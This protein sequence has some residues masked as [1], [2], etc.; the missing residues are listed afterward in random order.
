MKSVEGE[1]SQKEF[2]RGVQAAENRGGGKTWENIST[3]ER[4]RRT[5]LPGDKAA[6]PAK[7]QEAIKRVPNWNRK[8]KKKKKG[9]DPITPR[10]REHQSKRSKKK[11]KKRV[12]KA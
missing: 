4:R 7:S 8:G 5:P 3:I 12:V 10:K 6:R 2:S 9:K 1:T 11:S